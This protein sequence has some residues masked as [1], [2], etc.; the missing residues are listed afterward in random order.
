MLYQLSYAGMGSYLSPGAAEGKARAG[1]T[2][3][4]MLIAGG[5]RPTL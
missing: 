5:Q 2:W 1:R 4:A 3:H